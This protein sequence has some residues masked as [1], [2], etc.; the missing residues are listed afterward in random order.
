MPRGDDLISLTRAFI[1]AGSPSVVASLWEVADPST[2][3]LMERFYEHLKHE[4]KAIALAHAQR[5]MIAGQFGHPYYWAP[6]IL[7]GD[8]R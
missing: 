3:Q 2:A 1:Y 5:D 7:T 4:N 8:W 6:F